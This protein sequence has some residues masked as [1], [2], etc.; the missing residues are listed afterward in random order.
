MKR[1]LAMLF[2][3]TAFIS[4][5]ASA[6]V[7]FGSIG[8][9][10]QVKMLPGETRTF[11][12]SFFNGAGKPLYV[13]VD[14]EGSGSLGVSATPHDFVLQDRKTVGTPT[15]ETEWV[16]LREGYAKS[17]PVKIRVRV[18]SNVSK[19]SEKNHEITVEAVARTS[20]SADEGVHQKVAQARSYTYEVTIPGDI[21]VSEKKYAQTIES[22]TMYRR[23]TGTS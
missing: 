1:T 15:G 17:V 18:P 4:P 2:I 3:A 12:P 23:Y 19:I 7:S 8:H 11:T 9:N 10:R 20:S 6:E 21:G 13:H 14:V 22:N 5:V 16:Y